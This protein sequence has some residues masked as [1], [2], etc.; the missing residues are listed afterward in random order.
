MITSLTIFCCGWIAA[1]SNKNT[2]FGLRPTMENIHTR[3]V[4]SM[5]N[6]QSGPSLDGCFHIFLDV[7]A[8]WGITVRKL[9]EPHLYPKA[10]FLD[11]FDTYFGR[12]D[13]RRLKLSLDSKYICAVGFEPNPRHTPILEALEIAYNKCGWRTN[14]L[15]STA[16]SDKIGNVTFFKGSLHD[17]D[18]TDV[19]G[20]IAGKTWSLTKPGTPESSVVSVQL[21]DFFAEHIINRVPNRRVHAGEKPKI[22]VKMDTESSEI[23][24]LF[25][26][27]RNG[28]LTKMNFALV[29]YHDK[30]IKDPARIERSNKLE[31]FIH[32]VVKY[33]SQQTDK[34]DKYCDFMHKSG[35]DESFGMTTFP[36]PNCNGN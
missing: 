6:K 28:M 10:K 11:Y 15:K 2:L 27:I 32:E 20:T 17:K 9:Y 35:D 26:M 4:S 8:N 3:D 21:S 25:D 1:L 22:V 31:G 14:F 29:E 16:L 33:C 19:S 23:E 18:K 12:P 36:L 13:E 30:W 7:G 24:I 34:G 5:S